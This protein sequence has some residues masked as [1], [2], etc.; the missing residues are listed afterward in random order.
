MKKTIPCPLH[1]LC[2]ICIHRCR[3]P[4]LPPRRWA[5]PRRILACPDA[6][7]SNVS[8]DQYKGKYVV[9]EWTNPGCPFVRKHYDSGNMEKLQAEYTKKG[10]GC[11]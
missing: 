4:L 7:G 6:A 10:R 11:G 2:G 3:C 1:R 8:L 5:A 9:L